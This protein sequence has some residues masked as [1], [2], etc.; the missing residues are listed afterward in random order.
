MRCLRNLR[1]KI[2]RSTFE[3][4]WGFD[5]WLLRFGDLLVV[6]RT[7]RWARLFF[8]F[9][10]LRMGMGMKLKPRLEAFELKKPKNDKKMNPRSRIQTSAYT[11]FFNQ[12][13]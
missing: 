4:C 13:T 12:N 3:V 11:V 6:L 7:G 9:G 5:S 1:I 2:G 10:G 8:G